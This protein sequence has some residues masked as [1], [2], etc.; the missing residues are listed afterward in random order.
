MKQASRARL[1]CAAPRRRARDPQN[2]EKKFQSVGPA[3]GANWWPALYS[4]ST[5]G[6]PAVQPW[7]CTQ[8]HGWKLEATPSHQLGC[9]VVF[10]VV[11]PSRRTKV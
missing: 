3:L 6:V 11:Q 10:V 7:Y 2:C 1:G 9:I 4:H 5:T 8:V